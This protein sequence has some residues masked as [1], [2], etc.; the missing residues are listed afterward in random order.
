MQANTNE[1]MVTERQ[2]RVLPGRDWLALTKPGIVLSNVLMTA[3]GLAFAPSAAWGVVLACL[4]GTALLIAASGALNMV[5][6]A[7]VDKHMPRTAGRPIAAGRISVAAGAAFGAVLFGLGVLLLLHFTT[8]AATV[9]GV[10]ASVVYVGMYTP[11]KRWTWNAVP[12]GAVSGALP[13]IIGWTAAGGGFE[14]L[15]VLL[16][17][18]VFV[19]QLPHFLAIGIRR[20]KD[21]ADAG[22]YIAT[23]PQRFRRAIWGARLTAI[24]L[25]ALSIAV[26]MVSGAG[27]VFW[28]LAIL[29]STYMLA[30]AMR[31][32]D[33]PAAWAKKLFLSSLL[34]LPLFAIGAF[35]G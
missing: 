3:V 20:W 21:Y 27:P 31:S 33:E 35:I 19:W 1:A 34:Y 4:V 14:L 13:P 26:A 23:A 5:L 2:E 24:A 32:S 28:T 22:L 15:P 7:D 30:N 11:L 10:V 12:V 8:I 29:G 25:V 9:S 6:E 17:A 16:F 18:T